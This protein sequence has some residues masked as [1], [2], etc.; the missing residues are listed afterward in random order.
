MTRVKACEEKDPRSIVV[1]DFRRFFQSQSFN[2]PQ[3]RR[4]RAAL[5][6]RKKIA[7]A[8]YSLDEYIQ[9]QFQTKSH[10]AARPRKPVQQRNRYCSEGLDTSHKIQISCQGH[11]RRA[12]LYRPGNVSRTM[13]DKEH[14]F[15]EVVIAVNSMVLDSAEYSRSR[16]LY[17]DQTVIFTLLIE[18]LFF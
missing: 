12:D 18:L 14:C 13:Q 9:L 2:K 1:V 6:F 17:P 10:L 15:T 8:A 16:C 11:T 7:G 5:I 3:Q 4:T